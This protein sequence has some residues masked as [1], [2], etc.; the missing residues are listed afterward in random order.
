MSEQ[1]E[2]SV[3]DS[4]EEAIYDLMRGKPVIVVDDE[5][6]ENE[7]DFIALAEKASPEVINFMITEGRGLVCV[8]ITRRR[9]DELNLK[10]MVRRKY[11]FPW[12]CV[13]R[14]GRP[15]GD[16]DGDLGS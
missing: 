3:L 15:Y 12:D 1:S 10:P 8:P 7:G 5:D 4:I 9:A 14:L 6:R 2:P 11:R 16:N 13:H